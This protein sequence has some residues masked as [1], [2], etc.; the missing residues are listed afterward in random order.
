M[1]PISISGSLSDTCSLLLCHDTWE[2]GSEV[3]HVGSVGQ[4]ASGKYVSTTSGEG[5][6]GNVGAKDDDSYYDCG[7]NS[8]RLHSD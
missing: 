1:P 5:D 3:A 2:A 4:V 8:A 6:N 7:M